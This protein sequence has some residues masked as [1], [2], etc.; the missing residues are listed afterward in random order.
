MSFR[1]R[2][3]QLFIQQLRSKAADKIASVKQIADAGSVA[4]ASCLPVQSRVR[5]CC[6]VSRN[7]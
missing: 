6:M 7:Q 5:S 3:L 1:A 2:V 4:Y